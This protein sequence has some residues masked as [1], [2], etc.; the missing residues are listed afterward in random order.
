VQAYL[1]S[2]EEKLLRLYQSS[3][4]IRLVKGAYREP[5]EIAFHRKS[6]VDDNYLKL[7]Q[8]MLAKSDE[9]RGKIVFGTHDLSLLFKIQ[10]AT[11]SMNLTRDAYEIHMLYGIRS[12]D[13]SRLYDQGYPVRVLISYGD[14]WYPWYVRRLAERPANL[15][16]VLRNVFRR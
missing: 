1:F 12:S 7:A 13:Q 8:L 5:T 9:K 6:Q 16:F 14:A 15:F 10:T 4:H 11:E 3:A 2:T